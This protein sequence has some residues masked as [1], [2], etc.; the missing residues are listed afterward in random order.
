MQSTLARR[1]LS[2][3]IADTVRERVARGRIA[4]GIRINEVHLAAELGVS[5][6]PLR[7]ALMSL[8][9]EGSVQVEPRRGFFARPLTI[10][11]FEQ[12]VPMR[13]LLDPAAL[14]LA[15]LPSRP[16]LERLR[17][18]NRK[19][20]KTRDPERII[21]LDDAWHL[22]LLAHG[23]N[24]VLLD[25]IRQFMARTRRYE[26]VLMR[27]QGSVERASRDHARILA[28]LAAHDLA[29][30]CRALRRNMVSGSATI[31]AWLR[32]RGPA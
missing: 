8:V 7:E 6:T 29:G 21:A 23:T 25:L 20:E 5:R 19:L 2:G 10:G 14:E 16:Q 15:G 27:E 9:A 24:Q 11:E 4:P 18:I 3:E 1:N 26:L 17:E 12:L 28:A 22:E 31:L 30:A 13:A 32:Q